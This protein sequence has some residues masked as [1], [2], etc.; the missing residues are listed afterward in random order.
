MLSRV[1]RAFVLVSAIAAA[2]ASPVPIEEEPHH[3]LLLKNDYVEVFRTTVAPGERTLY[4]V[5]SHDN[6]GVVLTARTTT[7]QFLGKPEGRP[8][9]VQTGDVFATS[10]L[11]G[12][13]THRVHNV[14][15]GAMDDFDVEFLRRPA[16][17]SAAD[18]AP[19]AAENASARV[20]RWRLAP[21]TTT[22]MHVHERPYLIVAVT[23]MRLKMT[24]PDGKSFTH[25]VK[26]GDIHWIDTKVTHSLS[27]N[28]TTDG[29]IV[30]FEIK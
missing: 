13:T 24:A 17:P 25:D 26:P 11:E 15:N 22:A 21:G 1:S 9:T 28:G 16:Q 5:H 27:N 4:H 7:N 29:Q 6:A 10:R 19:V 3:H 30:E 2:Q 12:P 20:Y 8:E 23:S 18:T 14:G